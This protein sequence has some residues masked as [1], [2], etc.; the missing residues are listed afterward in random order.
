MTAPAIA[1]PTH[2]RTARLLLRRAAAADLNAIHEIM[3][4]A[5]VMRYWSSPTHADTVETAEWF[6]GML[7]ADRAGESDEFV[8]EHKGALIGKIGAWRLPEIGFFLRRDCWGRGFAMEAL[9]A[10]I[11]HV[12]GQGL[13]EL[14]AD[15]D[16]RND[17]CL[18]LLR[19][20]GFVESGRNK[21]TYVVNGH[22]CD[23]VYLHLDLQKQLRGGMRDETGT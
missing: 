2:L 13:G 5:E 11:D 18:R 23:S 4:D 15:V 6:D 21:A 14:T 8:I 16:P 1:K 7:E 19:K 12:K 20:C 10:Y 17:P 22:P 3:S 9:Q